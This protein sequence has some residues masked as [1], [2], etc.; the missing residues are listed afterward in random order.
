MKAYT[1]RQ[2]KNWTGKKLAKRKIRRMKA[3]KKIFKL[4]TDE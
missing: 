2:L 4:K 3:I 1:K